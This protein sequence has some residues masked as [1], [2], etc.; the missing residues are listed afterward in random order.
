MCEN[1][2]KKKGSTYPSEITILKK[3]CFSHNVKILF[4]LDA[5]DALELIA[6]VQGNE[7]LKVIRAFITV[8]KGQ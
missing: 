3:K 8:L 2:K 6:L 7:L 4:C 5:G 1:V